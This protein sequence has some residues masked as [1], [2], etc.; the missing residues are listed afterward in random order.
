M[1]DESQR[2]AVTPAGNPS[3]SPTAIVRPA[4]AVI[5]HSTDNGTTIEVTERGWYAPVGERVAVHQLAANGRD[6]I[7]WGTVTGGSTVFVACFLGVAPRRCW[8]RRTCA[9]AK[10]VSS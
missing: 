3:K 10:A 1:S 7:A 6:S 8:I 9:T 5:R 2:S 4:T